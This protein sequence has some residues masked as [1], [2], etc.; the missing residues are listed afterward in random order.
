MVVEWVYIAV[1]LK[2]VRGEVKGYICTV[3]LKDAVKQWMTSRAS[4]ETCRQR[5][6]NVM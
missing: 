1:V 5:T 2:Y 6:E 4:A 3:V